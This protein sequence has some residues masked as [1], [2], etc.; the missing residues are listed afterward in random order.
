M[1][2]MSDCSCYPTGSECNRWTAGSRR[3]CWLSSFRPS[4]DCCCHLFG[5]DSNQRLLNVCRHQTGFW[6]M[7]N[8]RKFGLSGKQKHHQLHTSVRRS[9]KRLRWSINA[10][11]N[12]WD[13]KV[14]IIV[15]I[16]FYQ[17][18]NPSINLNL[19]LHVGGQEK[20]NSFFCVSIRKIIFFVP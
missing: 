14:K 10:T 19:A 7:S 9:S 20:K 13:L 2:L 17:V 6:L 4:A 12:L 18:D 11:T 5:S 15:F 1:T 3:I 16:F 8:L